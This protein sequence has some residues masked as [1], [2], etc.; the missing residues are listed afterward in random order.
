[1][2]V[3][4]IVVQESWGLMMQGMVPVQGCTVK[5]NQRQGLATMDPQHG[6]SA[7]MRVKA[8]T[9]TSV[10]ACQLTYSEKRSAMLQVSMLL[11]SNFWKMLFLSLHAAPRCGMQLVLKPSVCSSFKIFIRAKAIQGKMK[12]TTKSGGRIRRLP[13]R[14]LSGQAVVSEAF[15]CMQEWLC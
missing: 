4:D 8:H 2:E 1:M 13:D 10:L 3:M 6:R 9:N 11:C 15:S 14:Q 7:V 12:C 5:G